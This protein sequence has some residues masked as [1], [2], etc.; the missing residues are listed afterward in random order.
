MH[1]QEAARSWQKV[2]RI[3]PSDAKAHERAAYAILKQDDGD[4]RVAAEHAKSAVAANPQEVAYHVTLA[5]IYMKVGHS[6][7]AK[8]AAETG[9]QLDP[10]N[11]TLLAILKK[12]AK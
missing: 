9:L 3:R 11:T 10:R 12:A 5:E 4:L 6:A 8:R 2:A 1:W 7:S